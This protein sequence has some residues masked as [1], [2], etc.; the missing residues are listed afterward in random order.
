M[1]AE[2]VQALVD[3]TA[4]GGAEVVALLKTGSA[5]YA[6]AASTFEM[7]EAILLDRKRVLPCATYL[8]GEYGVDGLFVGVPVVLGARGME[9]VIEIKLGADE[10]AA[11]DKS[12]SA[13]RELVAKL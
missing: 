4:N 13:V 10:Q 12:A 2:R 9:R 6:P 7:L 5:Y 8:Q 11:F 3:R 1:S